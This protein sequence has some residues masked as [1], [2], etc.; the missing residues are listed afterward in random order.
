MKTSFIQDIRR[1][2]DAGRLSREVDRHR[3]RTQVPF[4]PAGRTIDCLPAQLDLA[5]RSFAQAIPGGEKVIF[6]HDRERSLADLAERRCVIDGLVDIEQQH[7]AH[8]RR[9]LLPFLQG[10]DVRFLGCLFGLLLNL[11]HAVAQ[12]LDEIVVDLPVAF[13]RIA[14]Q[15]QMPLSCRH[16]AQIKYRIIMN[17]AGI[18][19]VFCWE[20]PSCGRMVLA[21][22]CK[23][24]SVAYFCRSATII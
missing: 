6:R 16:P 5:V 1:A 21:A 7:A 13:P 24:A 2:M 11:R 17:K 4:E 20:I 23:G 10:L 3:E 22:L 9:F 19:S 15:I 18:V 8:P 12:G 14:Q